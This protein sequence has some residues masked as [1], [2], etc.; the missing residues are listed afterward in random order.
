[1]T[2]HP[3][4]AASSNLTSIQLLRAVAAMSVVFF[5]METVPQLGIFGVDIF[6]VISGFV[7]AMVTSQGTT[8]GT[9]LLNRIIRIVPLYW[10]LTTALAVVVL[11]EPTL[12]MST[13]FN[14]VNYLKSLFFIPY[15]KESGLLQPFLF[16]GWTLNY[17]MLFYACMTTGLLVSRRW[18]I[19]ITVAL[20]LLLYL[21]FGRF[22]E[23]V[24]LTEFFGNLK[25]FEFVIGIAAFFSGRARVVRRAP[26]GLLVVT[27][28]ACLG[29]MSYLEVAYPAIDDLFRFGIPSFFLL[30]AAVQLEPHARTRALRWVATTIGDSS[31]A[32]YLSHAYVIALMLRVFL[33]QGEWLSSHY[34]LAVLIALAGSAIVG[35]LIYLGIDRPIH[36][37]LK[38]LTHSRRKSVGIA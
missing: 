17:E 25:L 33:K 28:I 32:I 20:L 30:V 3:A 26:P 4:S 29:G 36:R 23:N 18:H 22:S 14:L 35:R 2:T 6:F 11:V 1:M 12:I 16:V 13:T 37:Y 10:I 24:L 34:F 15:F 38:N 7:M 31:Y 27:C 21:V 5:H 9:F 19:Q 8:P